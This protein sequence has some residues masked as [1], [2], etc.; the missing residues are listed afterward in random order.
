MKAQKLN[1]FILEQNKVKANN[2]KSFLFVKFGD[3]LNI[4]TFQDG[5]NC[6]HNLSDE[7]H[8]VILDYEPDNNEKFEMMRSIKA[9]SPGI[10]VIMLTNEE[11]KI[12]PI[13]KRVN[14][15]GYILRNNHLM[16][17][18]SYTVDKLVREPIRYVIREFGVP[19]FIAV[20][21]STFTTM[22]MVVYFFLTYFG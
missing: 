12:D 22:G 18:L 17:K 1:L 13:S 16:R 2:L 5:Q 10:E 19:T 4:T 3:R 15:Y 20:F 9:V 8:I 11:S 21:F 6:L 7:T 14:Y